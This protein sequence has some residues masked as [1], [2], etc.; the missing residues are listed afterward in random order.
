MWII[1][2]LNRGK[3]LGKLKTVKYIAW[4]VFWIDDIAC[5]TTSVEV[6]GES[7]DDTDETKGRDLYNEAIYSLPAVVSQ[8][9]ILP[10]L[11]LLLLR[12]FLLFLSSMYIVVE[13]GIWTR[14][15]LQRLQHILMNMLYGTDDRTRAISTCGRGT[16]LSRY[17]TY[18]IIQLS[19]DVRVASDMTCARPA[20][21]VAIR[22]GSL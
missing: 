11:L 1:V 9:D 6:K 19:R 20:A 13:H 7:N 18:R 4:P 16:T 10:V 2:L 14:W 15:G 22:D 12:R 8:S 5:M 21:N 17:R 3:H